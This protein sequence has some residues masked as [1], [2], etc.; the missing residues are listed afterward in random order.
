MRG[1][2]RGK[3]GCKLVKGKKRGIER[4]KERKEGERG[5]MSEIRKKEIKGE[6]A[7]RHE[8]G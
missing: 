8:M 7:R 6:G 2:R 3:T 1:N 4:E 5:R